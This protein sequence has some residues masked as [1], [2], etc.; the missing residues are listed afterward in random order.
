MIILKRFLMV[1][2]CKYLI[3]V[4]SHKVSVCITA[5]ELSAP[6]HHVTCDV[7]CTTISNHLAALAEF[8]KNSF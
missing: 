2:N 8:V 5:D 7:T 1:L 6:R 4:E 3:V